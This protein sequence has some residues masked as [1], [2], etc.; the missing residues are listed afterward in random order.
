MPKRRLNVLTL[1]IAFFSGFLIPFVA[2]RLGKILPTTTGAI[3]FSLIHIPRFPKTHNPL[4]H[5]LFLR[6]W[7]SLC[8]SAVW[9][10]LLNMALFF[11]V[12]TYFPKEA[13]PYAYFFVWI[14][15]C[16]ANVD[17]RYFILPDCLTI[18]L[19]LLGFLFAT[20]T[21]LISAEQS[22]FG[23]CFAYMITA[24]SV[25]CLSFSRQSLFGAGDSKMAIALG[26]WLGIQGLNYAIFISFFLF[27][28]HA[29][30]TKKKYGAYGPALGLA[31]LFSFFALYT[32]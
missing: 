5:G 18:P 25:F 1:L 12:N 9:V 16:A 26:T 20:Q 28:L 4:R 15:L 23:A 3:L 24:L 14:L 21:N 30:W 2:R 32:K 6:R 31:G 13:I 22:V 17:V 8:W 27:V 29:Y 19:M 10:G 7:K 11:Y